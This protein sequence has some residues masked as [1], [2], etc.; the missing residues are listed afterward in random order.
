MEMKMALILVAFGIE[1]GRP[2]RN[3]FAVMFSRWRFSACS[4]Q[5][6]I[7]L[8]KTATPGQSKKKWMRVS[9]LPH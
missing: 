1:D 5:A 6:K 4:S 9:D 3:C 7:F 8:L 2:K